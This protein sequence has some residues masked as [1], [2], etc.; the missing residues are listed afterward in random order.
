M[1]GRKRRRKIPKTKPD[2]E[3][4]SHFGVVFQIFFGSPA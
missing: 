2:Y 1:G 3:N 4:A